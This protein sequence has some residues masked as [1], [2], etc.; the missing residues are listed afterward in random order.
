VATKATTIAKTGV[1]MT[2]VGTLVGTADAEIPTVRTAPRSSFAE[3]AELTASVE[4]TSF[5]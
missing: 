1:V 3:Q 5:A 2:T 4:V